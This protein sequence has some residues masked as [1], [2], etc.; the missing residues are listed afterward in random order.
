MNIDILKKELNKKTEEQ[1]EL[2]EQIK[3][4]NKQKVELLN[5]ELIVDEN[6]FNRFKGLVDRYIE[7]SKGDKSVNKIEENIDRVYCKICKKLFTKRLILDSKYT[8]EDGKA[9]YYSLGNEKM[10]FSQGGLGYAKESYWR[11]K[12]IVRCFRTVNDAAILMKNH[13]DLL[14][15]IP[16]K[17]KKKLQIYQRFFDILINHELIRDGDYEITIVLSPHI[18]TIIPQESE[19]FSSLPNFIEYG[20]IKEQTVYSMVAGFG[21]WNKYISFFNHNNSRI[22]PLSI[23]CNSEGQLDNIKHFINQ[24]PKEVLDKFKKI[25]ED[26]IREFGYLFLSEVI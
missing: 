15:N 9:H 4:I 14:R 26:L 3:E 13:M 1:L 8:E 25:Y 21:N 6:N 5:K 19:T 17:N 10:A 20:D 23:D 12:E 7:L 16:L 11:K 22:Y 24:L 2:F 18:T